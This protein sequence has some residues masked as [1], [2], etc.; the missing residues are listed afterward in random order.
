MD[1]FTNDKIGTEDDSIL[2]FGYGF[3]PAWAGP[4]LVEQLCLATVA[5]KID[6]IYIYDII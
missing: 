1:D 5:Q 3:I 2:F 4:T 6:P